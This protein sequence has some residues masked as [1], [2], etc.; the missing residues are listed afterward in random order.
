MKIRITYE[1]RERP[2]FEQI[3]QNVLKIAPD[4]RQHSSKSPGGLNAWYWNSKT[5]PESKARG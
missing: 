3:R 2:L 1:G 5:A 4:G